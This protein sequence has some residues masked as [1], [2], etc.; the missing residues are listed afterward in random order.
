MASRINPKIFYC[1]VLEDDDPYKTSLFQGFSPDWMNLPWAMLRLI[2]LPVDVLEPILPYQAMLARRMGGT[3]GWAWFPLSL[4][5]L[6]R[7]SIKQTAPFW[8]IFSGTET[9]A[10]AV[11]AWAET[12]VVR[13][14]HV[15]L[16]PWD[17]AITGDALNAATIRQHIETTLRD[18]QQRDATLDD[19]LIDQALARWRD[20]P[21]VDA[22]FP[23]R[24]HLCTLPNH[25]VLEAAGIRFENAVRL[26]G[27]STEDYVAAI[28]ETAD[29]VGRLRDDVGHV[30]AFR[31][32]PPQPALILTAPALFRH[33]YQDT[34]TVSRDDVTDP[35]I[36]NKVMR[37][38][39]RQKTF[40]L[41]LEKEELGR[42]LT[43]EEAKAIIRMRQEEVE[44]HSLA[45]GLRAA[46]TLATTI[47]VPPAVNRTAGVVHQVAKHAR[48]AKSVRPQ[49]FARLFSVVQAAL[50]E[51]V[52][53]DLL[54]VITE[55]KGGIK[56][57]T[58][59]PM[60]W[61]PI[62][63]LPLGLRFDCSRITATPGNLMAGQLVLP[64]LL[65][66]KPSAFSDVLVI[67]A[68]GTKDPI[69]HMIPAALD[70]GGPLWRDKLTIRSVAV[71]NESAFCD[72]LNAYD[73]GILIFDGH[74][75]HTTVGTL[76]IGDDSVDVWSLRGR[77]RVPPIVVLSACD[78]QAADRSHATTANGFLAAGARAV[79]GTL[80]PI[81]ARRAATFIGRLVY[82]LSD[83]LPA[84]LA[85]R[86][87]AIQWSEVVGGMLRM[88]LL[89]DLLEPYLTGEILSQE[90]CEYIQ[91]RGNIAINM[92][93]SDWFEFIVGLTAEC[94]SWSLDRVQE[95][96]RTRVPG[97]DTIRYVQM[98]NPETVLIDDTS[99]IERV[100]ADLTQ[101]S[102][103]Q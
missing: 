59:A 1:F 71:E 6:K 37:L 19:D 42:L 52:G 50:R 51:A 43:S 25:M 81:D 49:K 35:Q 89:A 103:L 57:V 14:L 29:A 76:A 45:V 11:S 55:T 82:R 94:L 65:R 34:P 41:F 63:A 70:M 30:P 74:G 9:T 47:R 77:V 60:E 12:Q 39:Q 97:S 102:P 48:A 87:E 15:T 85:A 2:D 53:P 38:L 68:F 33:V 98:G 69:R 5:A 99:L 40:Q 23:K 56:L 90:N 61:L 7:V 20:R 21:C 16:G 88:Q 26:I 54:Q 62:G 4:R 92:R 18:V 22:A 96:F 31:L 8:V 66:L 84:A 24:T 58:D 73:G 75:H 64:D 28:R 80:L 95:D 13:P 46:S 17:G 79:L 44:V 10:R 67:S 100:A 32:T 101:S 36:V 86:G 72:V 3:G 78:T 93:R 27:Q 91:T 83:F